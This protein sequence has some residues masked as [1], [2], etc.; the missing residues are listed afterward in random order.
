MNENE[1]DSVIAFAQKL[2]PTWRP[3]EPDLESWQRVLVKINRPESAKA[4]LTRLKDTSDWKGPKRREFKQF[5]QEQ[6][7]G[8]N[9]TQQHDGSCGMYVQCVEHSDPAHLGEFRTLYWATDKDMPGETTAY[10]AM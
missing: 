10:P 8:F 4:A 3:E 7:G 6:Q 9:S 2:W 1:S 5:I